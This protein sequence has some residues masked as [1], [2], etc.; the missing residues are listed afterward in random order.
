MLN[1][2]ASVEVATD[3]ET[4]EVHALRGPGFASVQF[5]LE[6]IL[7]TNGI[8]LL[9]ELVTDVLSPRYAAR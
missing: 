9:A 4:G 1:V 6:S 5:H 2:P 7:S 8:E 3:T